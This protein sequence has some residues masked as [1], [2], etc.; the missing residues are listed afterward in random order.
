[1]FIQ[2]KVIFTAQGER[3]DNKLLRKKNNLE[4]NGAYN[5]SSQSTVK[6][7]N[8]LP[9]LAVVGEEEFS[10]YFICRINQLMRVKRCQKMTFV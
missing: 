6:M 5:P 10:W 7:Y 3:N 8:P 2:P 1:M 9:Y 4:N